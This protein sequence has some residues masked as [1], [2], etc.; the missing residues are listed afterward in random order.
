MKSPFTKAFTLVELIVVIT[1]LSI[2]GTI[3]FVS[4]Q[5][6]SAN[7]R[8]SVRISD[9]RNIEK[10]LELY[11]Y[12]HNEYPKLS[13]GSI[14]SYSGSELWTQGSFDDEVTLAVGKINPKPLD[15]LTNSEYI[16]SVTYSGQE[17][18]IAGALERGNPVGLIS[19]TYA[20]YNQALVRGDFN[21]S[22]IGKTIAGQLHVFGVPSLVAITESSITLQEVLDQDLFVMN[23]FSAIPRGIEKAG[24]E[25]NRRVSFAPSRH[26]DGILFQG[27]SDTL[28]SK[29]GSLSLA[30]TMYEYYEGTGIANA[31]SL[32]SFTSN[33]PTLES[34]QAKATSEVSYMLASVS[35]IDAPLE[36]TQ[37]EE[38]GTQEE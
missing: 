11:H 7:A 24:E 8:D 15:P 27:S 14:V 5:G 25:S 12:S 9:L 2:L 16:Y 18:Q 22:V 1:I 3:G 34:N 31:E 20:N 36:V 23:K 35:L 21:G 32:L 17:Y 13:T 30:Q 38:I 19:E 6:Y 28:A 10:S 37:E 26:A 29:T 4:L 33:D